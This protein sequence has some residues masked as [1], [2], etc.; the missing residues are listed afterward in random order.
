M[1][2]KKSL[3]HKI[4]YSA[5]TRFFAGFIA[6]GVI[7]AFGQFTFNKLFDLSFLEPEYQSLIRGVVLATLVLACYYFLYK[8]YEKRKISEL[9][10]QHLLRHLGLGIALGFILQSLTIFVIYL[11]GGFTIIAVNNILFLIPALT[12]AFTAA[13]I[14]EVLFRGI[15]YRL[16]EEK[17]GSYIA[18]AI[19]ALIFGAM[20]L[21][22]PNSSFGA[23]MAIAI[24]AGLLLGAVYIYSKNLWLPIALHFAW[25]FTQSGIYGASTSGHVIEKSLFTT[26]IEGSDLIT[27][28]AFGPEASIQAILFCVIAMAII[29]ILNHRQ[30]KIIKPFWINTTKKIA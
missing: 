20:H 13:I 25:N 12:M 23:G 10:R 15:L 3:A 18:L 16:M 22:N 7:I 5:I 19:S 27:G 28:G 2:N 26:T 4:L 6:C 14:E 8:Y 11:F 21:G 9:S 17:L 24:E 29:M 30:R 1:D